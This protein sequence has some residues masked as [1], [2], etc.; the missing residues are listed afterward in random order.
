MAWHEASEFGLYFFSVKKQAA[1]GLLIARSSSLWA[2]WQAFS[3]KYMLFL[4][5]PSLSFALFA[6]SFILCM[7]LFELRFGSVHCLL[8]ALCL[9]GSTWNLL[10]WH[11]CADSTSAH[12]LT[13]PHCPGGHCRQFCMVWSLRCLLVLSKMS[14]LVS[15]GYHVCA[16]SVVSDSF[17]TPWTVA[18]QAP[19]S[20]GFP[21]QEYS[22]GLPFFLPGDLPNPG[23]EPVSPTSPSG[24]YNN[25]KKNHRWV[26]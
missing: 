25:S 26:T 7:L 9:G 19:L 20:T 5:A 6:S 1:G 24:Y 23:I 22:S 14:V 8:W 21:R 4:P 10:P 13:E 12:V 16:C 2:C 18:H 3:W 15:S 17:V 11:G